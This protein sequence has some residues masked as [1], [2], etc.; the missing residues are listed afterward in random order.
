MAVPASSHISAF[1]LKLQG[2]AAACILISQL[3]LIH[4]AASSSVVD[5]Q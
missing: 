5:M 2:D 3:G 4:E 1:T